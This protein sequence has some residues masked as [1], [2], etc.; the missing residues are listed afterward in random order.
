MHGVRD[1][2]GH[3]PCARAG[4]L[5]LQRRA[6]R[7]VCGRHRMPGARHRNERSLHRCSKLKPTSVPGRAVWPQTRFDIHMQGPNETVFFDL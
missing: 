3:S 1:E 4:A 2:S 5:K 7:C 6:R